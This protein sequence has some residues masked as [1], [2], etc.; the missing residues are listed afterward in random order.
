MHHSMRLASKRENVEGSSAQGPA[1]QGMGKQRRYDTDLCNMLMYGTGNLSYR[2][3]ILGRKANQHKAPAS[4][5]S[6]HLTQPI[7]FE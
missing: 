3:A 6:A 4:A 1:G 2:Q 5:R 7:Q